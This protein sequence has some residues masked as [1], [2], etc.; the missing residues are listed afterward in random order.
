[1][2]IDLLLAQLAADAGVEL[3]RRLEAVAERLLDHDAPPAMRLAVAQF[4]VQQAGMAEV[5][6]HRAEEAVGHSEVEQ[7]VAAGVVLACD[8]VQ[9]QAQ[10]RRTGGSLKS[11]CM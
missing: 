4:L 1:M 8:V 5:L 6:D 9:V 2:R 11:P 3:A 7:A 10:I